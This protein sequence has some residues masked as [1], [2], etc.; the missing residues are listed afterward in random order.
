VSELC[1]QSAE[2]TTARA[3]PCRPIICEAIRSHIQIRRSC[4]LGTPAAWKSAVR[5]YTGTERRVTLA[6]LSAAHLQHG[7]LRCADRAA[8]DASLRVHVEIVS[9][10]RCGLQRHRRRHSR[11]A[12]LSQ[13]AM[14]VR[15]HV[16][17]VQA[18]CVQLSAYGSYIVHCSHCGCPFG[19]IRSPCLAVHVW[20]YE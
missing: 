4:L 15:A 19:P 9:P 7:M 3:V 20:D 1:D 16:A 13:V 5:E 11:A 2:R 18:Q 12:T 10:R 6:Q 17:F 14:A 8:R